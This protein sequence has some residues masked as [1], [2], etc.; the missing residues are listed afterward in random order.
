MKLHANAAL[1]MN[2]RRVLV[3]RVLE[4]RVELRR[5][6]DGVRDA[7]RGDRVLAQELAP[8]VAQRDLVDP[9]DGDVD[10]VAG[11]ADRGQQVPRLLRIGTAALTHV[12]GGVDDEL[13]SGRRGVDALPRLQVADVRPGAGAPREH[14]HLV[15]TLTQER[16]ER[17]AEDPRPA[18]D[19]DDADDR[20]Y[21]VG[22]AA[23]ASCGGVNS[24]PWSRA[25][26]S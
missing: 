7:A 2:R 17:R 25:T 15:A 24:R 1:S 9:D 6:L 13:G 14:A 21:A 23:S 10:H 18:G 8:V 3:E 12:G 26:G 20:A 11:V 22:T 4:Q 19:E 16:D 5:A